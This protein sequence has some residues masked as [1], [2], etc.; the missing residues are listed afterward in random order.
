MKELVFILCLWRANIE[1]STVLQLFELAIDSNMET[2]LY[3]SRLGSCALMLFRS[4]LT[5]KC[6]LDSVV[7]LFGK[8]LES[9]E[10]SRVKDK[11]ISILATKDTADMM[12][13]PSFKELPKFVQ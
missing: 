11:C 2:L 3:R 1:E 12:D 13:T 6:K 9:A 10:M 5:K 7:K 8:T 4:L